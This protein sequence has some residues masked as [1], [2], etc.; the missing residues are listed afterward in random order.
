MSGQHAQ[1]IPRPR[2]ITSLAD[3]SCSCRGMAGVVAAVA[4][5]MQIE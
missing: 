3:G 1:I 2:E 5:A 4:D